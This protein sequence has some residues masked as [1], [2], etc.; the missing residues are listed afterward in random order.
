MET[1]FNIGDEV[2]IKAK[3]L[4]ISIAPK[5]E[6]VNNILKNNY[7]KTMIIYKLGI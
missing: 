4:E 6:M 7:E 1:R 5:K 3:V 2:T